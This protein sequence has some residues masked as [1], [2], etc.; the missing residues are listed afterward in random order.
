M[1]D[2]RKPGRWILRSVVSTVVLATAAAAVIALSARSSA[3]ASRPSRAAQAALPGTAERF[4]V[5][6][7][8]SSNQCGLLASSL[9]RMA[10]D[11]QLQGSCCFPM[12]LHRYREQVDGLRRYADV[13]EIPR[14]PYDVPVTLARQLIAYEEQIELNA[15]ELA[16]YDRAM[17]VSEEGGPCCCRCWRWTAFG[18]QAKFLI[19]RRGYEAEQIA[20]VWELEDGCGGVGHRGHES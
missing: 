20:E 15:A 7:R 1:R 18:G 11:G 13:P 6:S 3:D 17:K 9:E 19:A 12:D 5:L 14:D 4:A 10:R 8:A 16:T 2:K